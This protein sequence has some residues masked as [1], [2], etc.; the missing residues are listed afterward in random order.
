MNE[1]LIHCLFCSREI[2]SVQQAYRRVV[3]WEKPRRG[4]GTNALAVRQ[5]TDVF[6]CSICID[7]LRRG[8]D[9]KQASL[10]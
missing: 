2:A 10:L 9:P 4:G 3:G 7:K 1:S 8:I 5:P 6:A